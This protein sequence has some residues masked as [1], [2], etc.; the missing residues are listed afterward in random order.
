MRHASVGPVLVGQAQLP[1]PKVGGAHRACEARLVAARQ[2]IPHRLLLPRLEVLRG[3]VRLHELY[4]V[5]F[6]ARKGGAAG[7]LEGLRGEACWVDCELGPDHRAVGAAALC[8]EAAE[9]RLGAPGWLKA[10]EWAALEAA[11]SSTR[12]GG[13]VPSGPA[14]SP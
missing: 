1:R 10:K 12:G 5:A 13:W 9:Q 8:T 7:I 11:S 6:H 2:A 14:G 3:P 4:L